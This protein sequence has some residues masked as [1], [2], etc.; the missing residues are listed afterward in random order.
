MRVTVDDIMELHPCPDYPRERVD[1]LWS[2]RESLSLVEICDLDIPIP[3]R[4][5]AV[6]GL[7]PK[8]DA[9]HYACDCAQRVAHLNPDPRVQA[10]IDAARRYAD[11]MATDDELSAAWDAA[12]D[13]ARAAAWADA[14]ADA[15]AAARAARAAWDAAWSAAL[16][17][18]GDAW[19]AAGGAE[20]DWQIAAL[21]KRCQRLE[22]NMWITIAEA[23][24]L[25][26]R[27]PQM[28]RYWIR[29]GELRMQWCA[30]HGRKGPR[31][32]QCVRSEDLERLVT[33]CD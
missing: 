19:A 22:G 29:L 7:M 21:R 4:I 24:R 11:G 9:R 17:A 2:G 20:R 14:W 1:E 3:D 8:R 18:A 6:T 27:S 15:W 30:V 12:W 33:K 26:D 32:V 23:A 13:A 5:W 25:A 31:M 28:I 16:A 10:A